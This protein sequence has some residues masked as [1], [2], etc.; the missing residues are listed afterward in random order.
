MHPLQLFRFLAF[1]TG[2]IL[3]YTGIYYK[4]IFLLLIGITTT[5][6][7]GVLYMTNGYINEK[8]CVC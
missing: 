3:I 6:I 7:D 1:F 8:G 5:M 2:V 4:N